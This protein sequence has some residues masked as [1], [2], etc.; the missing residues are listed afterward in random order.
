MYQ[1]L[2]IHLKLNT[3]AKNLAQYSL[4]E[5]KKLAETLNIKVLD[6]IWQQRARPDNKSYV[7]SGKL[8]DIKNRLQPENIDLVVFNTD[9]SPSQASYIE[10]KF[11]C[12]V[13]DRT[14]L[15]LEIFNQHAQTSEAK[16]QVELARLK[17][18]LPRLVGLWSHLDREKGGAGVSKGMGEKQINVDKKLISQRITRLNQAL[19]KHKKSRV[20]QNKRRQKHWQVALV[21]YTNS[22][23]SSLLRC[24][25]DSDVH[26]KQQ[27][28]STLSPKTKAV[29]TANNLKLLVSDTVG[30]IQDLPHELVASFRSTLEHLKSAD[31]LLH[32]VD[33]ADPQFELQIQTTK[34]VLKEIGVFGVQTLL[35]FN[36]IDQ[37]ESKFQKLLL[38][39]YHRSVQVSALELATKDVLLNRIENCL[40]QQWAKKTLVIPY[41]RAFLVDQYYQQNL[42]QKIDYTDEGIELCL[43]K[44]PKRK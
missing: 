10:K 19:G 9:L 27:L 2:L 7:G 21:G 18:M 41:Q 37:V 30:F 26:V 29:E 24:I 17:Y 28:F 34:Q 12:M 1:A 4:S 40:C 39:D 5:L 8:L 3:Q 31:L 13:W 43:Y 15:I 32:V 20:E 6:C 36:K 33:A 11:E 14:Q 44:N 35:V 42:V 16:N 38:A 25:S 22:G 23:K